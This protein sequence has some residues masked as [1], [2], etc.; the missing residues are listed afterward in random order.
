MTLAD[1]IREIDFDVP[2]PAVAER[3]GCRQE[4]VRAVRSRTKRPDHYRDLYRRYSKERYER[5]PESCLEAAK[6]WQRKNPEKVA[7]A[8]R[9]YYQKNKERLN[10]YNREYRR[11]RKAEA[12]S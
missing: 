5:D 2:A 10:E 6:R 11:R 12:Q 4:Y 9:A 1:Q 3:L 7:A 8:H